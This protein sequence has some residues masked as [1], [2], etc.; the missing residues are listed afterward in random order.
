M[1]TREARM[2]I[3][4]TKQEKRILKSKSAKLGM[5]VAEYARTML[6]HSDDA[7]IGNR[8]ASSFAG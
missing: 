6:I 4:L 2:E 8:S 5:S 1:P 7:C 3:R